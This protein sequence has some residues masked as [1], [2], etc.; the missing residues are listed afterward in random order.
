[1]LCPHLLSHERFSCDI[2]TIAFI[3]FNVGLNSS[4]GFNRT[5][6][7]IHSGRKIGRLP[8][9]P[10]CPCKT[11]TRALEVF[12]LHEKHT[13]W[14]LLEFEIA[15]SLLHLATLTMSSTDLLKQGR[16]TQRCGDCLS[17]GSS[18]HVSPILIHQFNPLSTFTAALTKQS[19]NK[20]KSVNA[21]CSGL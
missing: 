11:R 13:Y 14:Q 12:H 18:L 10:R 20:Q 7:A 6:A 9:F 1:M 15:K 5:L 17:I 4:A 8:F 3:F 2:L 21:V 16:H 19:F